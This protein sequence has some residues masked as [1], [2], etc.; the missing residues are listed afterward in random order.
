MATSPWGCMM[1]LSHSQFQFLEKLIFFLLNKPINIFLCAFLLFHTESLSTIKTYKHLYFLV[2]IC[3]ISAFILK[4]QALVK[5][6][7]RKVGYITPSTGNSRLLSVSGSCLRKQGGEMLLTGWRMKRCL[8]HV[9]G[10]WLSS[11][12]LA[13]NLSQGN[14]ASKQPLLAAWSWQARKKILLNS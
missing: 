9:F 8:R 2:C 11:L 5:W 14:Q 7:L 4:S 12:D 1:Y 13:R 6:N 3:T 10:E